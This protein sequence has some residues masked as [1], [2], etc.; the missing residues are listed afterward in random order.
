MVILLCAFVAACSSSGHSAE[1]FDAQ[2]MRLRA[3]LSSLNLKD[4]GADA[5]AHVAQGDLRPVGI[6]GFTCSI[7][8]PES[9]L[10]PPK[11]GV[12]CLDGTSDA[13][14]SGEHRR[15]IE[16]AEVYALAYDQELKKITAK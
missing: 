2:T 4:P 16:A 15:L 1:H 6:Y 9:N 14:E 12:R 3:T 10:P 13:L 7:P 5:R 8:G 11:V